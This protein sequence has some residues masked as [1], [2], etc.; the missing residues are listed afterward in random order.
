MNPHTKN[1]EY[2]LRVSSVM[3]ICSKWQLD[4]Q[5]LANYL[6]FKDKCKSDFF[7]WL[8]TN[9]Y[10]ILENVMEK[11]FNQNPTHKNQNG[12]SDI[13]K[14][15]GVKSKGK[16]YQK[17]WIPWPNISAKLR[18]LHALMQPCTT[19]LTKLEFL[20]MFLTSN[21]LVAYP[22]SFYDKLKPM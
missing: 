12:Y 20:F 4:L 13:G 11:S 19:V 16:W 18:M 6:I 15:K 9:S 22:Y 7:Q 5:P 1:L 2:P 3:V 8:I 10:K 17:M 21:F 14:Q